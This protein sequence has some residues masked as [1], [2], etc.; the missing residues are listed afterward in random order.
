MTRLAAVFHFEVNH[1]WVQAQLL[2]TSH[3]REYQGTVVRLT[4][5]SSER[6]FGLDAS[7]S[8]D[9]RAL[10]G[11]SATAEGMSAHGVGMVQVSVL[12]D[13]SISSGDFIHDPPQHIMEAGF[14]ALRQ[15]YETATSFLGHY[16]DLV[17][18]QGGQYWLGLT[19]ALVKQ[20]WL[21]ILLEHDTGITLPVSIGPPMRGHVFDLDSALTT[22]R[23]DAIAGDAAQHREPSLPG[24]LLADAKYLGWIHESE[25]LREAVLLAAIACEVK[26]KSVLRNLVDAKSAPLLDIIIDNPSDVSMPVAA[27]FSR[28]AKAIAGHSLSDEDG[29]L[30]RAVEKLFKVRNHIAHRGGMGVTKEQMREAVAAASKAFQ[31]LESIE[32]LGSISNTESL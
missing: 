30:Y 15:A 20:V 9:L 2:G 27:L 18:T 22:E 8:L 7:R 12:F 11:K 19:G 16:L 14:E 3:V 24:S 21:S 1:L 10:T 4:I 25:D 26:I 29:S 32:A 13:A 28:A 17:H 31:W 5:P 23:H 6:D